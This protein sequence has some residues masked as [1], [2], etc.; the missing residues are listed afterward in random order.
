MNHKKFLKW[1][2]LGYMLLTVIFFVLAFVIEISLY[3]GRLI[4]IIFMMGLV[5]LST[6]LLIVSRGNG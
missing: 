6:S 5:W 4:H 2:S 1:I 3:G